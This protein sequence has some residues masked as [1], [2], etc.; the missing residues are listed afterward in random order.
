MKTP[1]IILIAVGV[2]I[3]VWGA[4]GFQTRSHVLDAGPIHVTQETTHSVP[5]GSLAGL[6]LI[7]GGVVLMVRSK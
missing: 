3:L 7:A 4:F 1:A 2:A 5:Y 6:L